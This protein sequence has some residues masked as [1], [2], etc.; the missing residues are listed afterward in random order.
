MRLKPVLVLTLVMSCLFCLLLVACSNSTA[1]SS[2]QG[3]TSV[4]S[5]ATPP[6][7]AETACQVVA[8][9]ST[10][11]AQDR[12]QADVWGLYCPNAT[13]G[14]A[15]TRFQTLPNRLIQVITST[16]VQN[17]PAPGTGVLEPKSLQLD[18]QHTLT[19]YI[20]TCNGVRF[21]AGELGNPNPT[22]YIVPP[23]GRHAFLFAFPDGTQ[24]RV[25]TNNGS[26]S[27]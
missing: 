11:D 13:T 15:Y 27:Q 25:H 3:S 23:Q 1:T 20:G 21:M 5:T 24:V 17:C 6:E 12:T 2:T 14:Y 19:L 16:S 10:Y 8:H 22:V 4:Q 18:T 7:T 26:F 9:N